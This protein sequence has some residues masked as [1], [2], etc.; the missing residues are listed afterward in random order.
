MGRTLKKAVMFHTLSLLI[1]PRYSLREICPSVEPCINHIV[2]L[3]HLCIL[4]LY[5]CINSF[6]AP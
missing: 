2:S 3:K 1:L 6:S 4:H 5:I